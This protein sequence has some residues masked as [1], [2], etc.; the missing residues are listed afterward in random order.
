MIRKESFA[1]EKISVKLKLKF[2]KIVVKGEFCV[3]GPSEERKTK[4][5]TNIKM[6]NA[7]F[8]LDPELCECTR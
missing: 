7:D 5:E 2:W 6:D 1:K 4:A 3:L 8:D